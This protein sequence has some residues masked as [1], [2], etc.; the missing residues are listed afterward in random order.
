MAL[1]LTNSTLLQVKDLMTTRVRTLSPETSIGLAQSEMRA[2]RFRHFPVVDEKGRLLGVVSDRDLYRGTT[3]EG[4]GRSRA[5]KEVMTT[6]MQLVRPSTPAHRAVRMMLEHKIG[7]LPVIDERR[8]LVG[9][10]TES[11]FLA[12]AEAALRSEPVKKKR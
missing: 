5:V 12:V 9:V 8:G 3:R 7:M 6:R 10:I 2:A 1:V 4:E 11:D